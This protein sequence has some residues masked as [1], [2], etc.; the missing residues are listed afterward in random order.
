MSRPRL[1]D[2]A[3]LKPKIVNIIPKPEIETP[4]I[5]TEVKEIGIS[6]N[7]P[8]G[9]SIIINLLFIISLTFM[10]LWLYHLYID[11]KNTIIT[12]VKDIQPSYESV[13]TNNVVQTTPL[14]LFA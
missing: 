8:S 12:E 4:F 3:T 1:V 13:L 5:N 9:V 11:R 6:I 2:I 7:P 14:A 10:I